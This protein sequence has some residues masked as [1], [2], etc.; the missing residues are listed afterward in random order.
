MHVGGGEDFVLRHHDVIAELL[1]EQLDSLD[2][3]VCACLIA[4]EE[5]CSLAVQAAALHAGFLVCAHR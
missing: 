2:G 1:V 4:L 3:L 5:R